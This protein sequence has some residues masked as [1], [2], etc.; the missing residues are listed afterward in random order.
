FRLGLM[1]LDRWGNA[2][3]RFAGRVVL[4]ASAPVTGLPRELSIAKGQFGC[5]I[6]GLSVAEI[7]DLVIDV[8]DADGAL[9]CKSN[10]LRIASSA[11]ASYWA[12]FHAQSGETVGAG[13]ARDYFFF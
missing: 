7:C 8:R 2:T 1:P 13:T 3:D 6:E 11:A 5:A 12:D 9:L 10:P 4:Q